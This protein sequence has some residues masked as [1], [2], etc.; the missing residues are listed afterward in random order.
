MGVVARSAVLGAVLASFVIFPSERALAEPSCNLTYNLNDH[1]G[2]GHDDSS[3]GTVAGIRAPVQLRR[4]GTLCTPEITDVP[5]TANYISLEDDHLGSSTL[6]EIRQIGWYDYPANSPSGTSAPF[7]KFYAVGMGAGHGY[8]C[9]HTDGQE[10]NFQVDL[11][12]DSLG[13]AHIEMLDCGSSGWSACT[14]EAVGGV[15]N[16]LTATAVVE[17]NYPC[18]TVEP[19]SDPSLVGGNPVNYGNSGYPLHLKN[20]RSDSWTTINM[21][22][23]L[24]LEFTSCPSPNNTNHYHKD[25]NATTNVLTTWDDRNLL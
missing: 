8:E 10:T 14:P 4:Q 13:N 3:D 17:T 23:N 16:Y 20:N 19:G 24:L 22:K 9:N 2:R 1:L 7:C 6:G 25:W 18:Q 21:E 11:Y 5:F 12:T 15:P